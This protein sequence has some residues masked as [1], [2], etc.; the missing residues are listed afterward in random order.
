MCEDPSPT[1]III[2]DPLIYCYYIVNYRTTLQYRLIVIVVRTTIVLLYYLD[3]QFCYCVLHC[4][5]VIVTH[6]LHSDITLPVV[7]P[8]L[9]YGGTPLHTV[10]GYL[11]SDSHGTPIVPVV[12]LHG[13]HY[14]TFVT[15]LHLIDCITLTQLHCP[16]DPVPRHIAGP[17]PLL[18]IVLY[19]GSYTAWTLVV[20]TTLVWT[21]GPIEP[22]PLT[23]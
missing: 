2:L 22:D 16:A 7:G 8:H 12:A 15:T 4:A 3:L 17:P 19:S 23:L 6:L 5:V 11:H 13:P 1:P 10:T 9:R 14:S 21:I 20:P 18:P